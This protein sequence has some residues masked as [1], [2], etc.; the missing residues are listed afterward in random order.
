MTDIVLKGGGVKG[1]A[2]GGGG[3]HR[4][5]IEGCEAEHVLEPC[6]LARSVYVDMCQITAFD[7]DLTV[8]HQDEV[9]TH[10]QAAAE[11]FLASW[12]YR[13]WLQPCRGQAATR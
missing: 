12:D 13:R 6:N 3:T 2:L 4:D 1:I 11:R 5:A 9:L 8:E 10:G 7:F